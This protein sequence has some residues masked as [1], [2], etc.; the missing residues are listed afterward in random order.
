MV[1]SAIQPV[2]TYSGNN[3]AKT[4]DFGFLINNE[5]ELLVQ[6]TSIDGIQSN[7][8]LNTDYSINEVGNKN[9]SYITFPLVASAYSTLGTGEKITLSL[10]LPIKQETPY[11]TSSGLNLGV[12]EASFDYATRINQIQDRKIDRCIKVKEG[13]GID[14]D[15]LISSLEASALT[16]AN[17]ASA[18]T[19]SATGAATSATNAATQAEAAEASA[20]QAAIY[21]QQLQEFSV[22]YTATIGTTWVGSS[23]PF[24]Q[25]VAV[26][27]VLATDNAIV[28]LIKSDTY[29]TALTQ[30]AEYSKIYKAVTSADKVTFYANEPTSS[31]LTVQ[32]KAVR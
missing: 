1:V 17:S 20:E 23:A 11:G 32:I 21:A 25:E 9:G 6:F 7:L 15:D 3:S 2:V 26:S 12:L 14:P 19:A 28:G 22:T 31:A 5:A 10:T 18:A 24:S 27:G 4:F 13:S 29:A 30:M 16:A 8:V